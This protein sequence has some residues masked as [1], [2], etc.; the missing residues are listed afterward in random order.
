MWYDENSA[1]YIVTNEYLRRTITDLM[2]EN[3]NRVLTVAASG[4]HPL[5]CSLYGA[6]YVDTFDIS[7]NAKC[8][9]DIKTAAIQCL[10]RS[11]YLDLLENLWWTNDVATVPDMD[12]ISK[13]L[14]Q[15]EFEYLC[16]M[17]GQRLFNRG[18]WEGHSNPELP[19]DAEYQKLQNI[20]KQNYNFIRTDI[21]QLSTYL[22]QG[23]DFIH[24]SNIFDYVYKAKDRIDM[25]CSLLK[26]VNVGGR[27]C[28]QYFPRS[29]IG[30]PFPMERLEQS[31]L[32]NTVL[33]NWRFSEH[34]YHVF[35]FDHIR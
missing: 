11:K 34:L 27:I 18:S 30:E 26:Y 9:M 32:F 8:V 28:I 16:S 6:K 24:V 13:M 17:K 35:T 10:N 33:K 12:K 23:Y 21:A 7:R 14:P 15:N 19:T 3:C 20:I 1:A 29:D 31:G 4:D 22:T 5:F 25:L 2:P